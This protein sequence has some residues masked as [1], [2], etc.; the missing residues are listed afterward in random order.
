MSKRTD[1][2]FRGI[3][4]KPYDLLREGLVVLLIVV[5]AVIALAAAFSSPDYPTVRA[6]DVATRQPI[7]FLETSAGILAGD[8]SIQDYG[9]PYTHNAASSQNLFGVAP[10]SW[11][12]VRDPI[13]PRRD[14]IL[15]PLQ[16]VAVFNADVAR[17]LARYEAASPLQ[18][19]AWLTAYRSALGKATVVNDQ[20][21]LPAADYGPVSALMSGML[22]LGRSGL[23]EG[24]L[25]SNARL[26]FTLDL[27]RSLLFFQDNV[28]HNVAAKLDMLGEQWGVSHETGAYPGAWW[29]LP[30]VFLYQVRPMSSSSSGDLQVGV[31]M[32]LFFLLTVLA[33]FVPVVNRLPRWLRV[34]RLIW[35]DWYARGRP[36]KGGSGPPP[37]ET[38]G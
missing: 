18:Q 24:A 12:G 21:V 13:D 17:A 34:H 26:P 11:F 9:P 3:P 37:V 19:Q 38:G 22:A 16:R 27:T 30:Y 20:V 14:F 36:R 31:I 5:V 7:A 33:P 8:S 4:T 1:A 10:A 35:R 25:E 2:Y 6:Q 15:K 29:L 23:L 32:S 28:D